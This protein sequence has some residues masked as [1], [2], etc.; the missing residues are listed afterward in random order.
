MRSHYHFLQ[1]K[2]LP[3][4]DSRPKTSKFQQTEVSLI[5]LLSIENQ[6]IF[7]KINSA[8]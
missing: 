2:W 4:S 8:D 7:P 1:Q 3:S 5:D 6:I